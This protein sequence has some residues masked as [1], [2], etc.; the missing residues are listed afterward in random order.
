MKEIFKNLEI[1]LILVI[2]YL[3]LLPLLLLLAILIMF[4][5][6]KTQPFL[7]FLAVTE[8]IEHIHI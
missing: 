8:I 7:S 2:V 1:V 4:K 6:Q 5:V 3:L